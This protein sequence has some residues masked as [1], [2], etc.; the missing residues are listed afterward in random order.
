MSLETLLK[1]IIGHS[2]DQK[3]IGRKRLQKTAHLLKV[4]GVQVGADFKIHH[5]GP[6]SADIADKID[7]L[8]FLGVIEE[9]QEPVGIY[10]TSQYVYRMSGSNLPVPIP[11]EKFAKAMQLLDRRSVIELEV[12]S[13]IAFFEDGSLDRNKALEAVIEMKP[14][15]AIPQVITKASKLI[16]DLRHL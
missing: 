11:S 13:T 4:S 9:S 16:D 8:V 3:I 14:S 15:K 5:Y 6:F 12:A 1:A 7:E 2:T 10:G